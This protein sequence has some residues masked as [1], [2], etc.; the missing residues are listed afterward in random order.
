MPDYYYVEPVQS[1]AE[2]MASK[3]A[4]ATLVMLARNTDLEGVVSSMRRLE[5]RFNRYRLHLPICVLPLLT[6]PAYFRNYQYPWV[7]LNE[8]EF[9]EDFKRS[10]SAIFASHVLY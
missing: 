2:I 6:S 9:T 10:A 7:F 5:D 1:E 8:V 3:R 4:N